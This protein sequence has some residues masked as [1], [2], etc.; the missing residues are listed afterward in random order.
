[1][2]GDRTTNLATVGLLACA[3]TMTLLAARHEFQPAAPTVQRHVPVSVQSDWRY[4]TQPG[5][6]LGATNAPVTI[7][8]FADFECPYCRR[9][10]TYAES[11][12]ALGKDFKVIY[13]HYPLHVHRFALLAARASECASAQ[14]R[15]EPMH[16]LLYRNADSLG[17]A[18]WWWFA[19]QAGVR[20]SSRFAK[21]LRNTA[22]ATA[23][24]ADTAAAA[25]LGATGT[26][27][28]LIGS[29]RIDGLPSFDS[30][31]AYVDRAAKEPGAAVQK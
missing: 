26:P 19:S 5:H 4:Y 6:V 9:F 22:N 8:E 16:K 13:R 20:D 1:M 17:L 7:V 10:E 27:T 23:V 15:F 14:D 31:L 25:R 18:P 12:R 11:L 28:L 30:L 3:V 29:T 24:A 21:C 2:P